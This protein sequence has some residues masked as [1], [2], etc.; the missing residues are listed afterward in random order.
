MTTAI[1]NIYSTCLCLLVVSIPITVTASGT[2]LYQSVEQALNTNPQLQALSHN[3]Q[4]VQ[5]DLNQ[6]RGGYLPTVD[7][8]LGYGPEQHSDTATRSLSSDN[9]WDPRTDATLRLTQKVYDGGETGNLVS[10]RKAQLD[11]AD[12]QLQAAAQTVALDAIRAHLNV[13]QQR[14]LV[15]LA[16]KN[17]KFHR[18]IL[19]SLAEKERAGAGSIADVTQTQ[20]RLAR[21]ESTLYLNQ[22]GL[23]QTIANYTRVVG[24][25]PG[26]LVYAG[27][28]DTEP[29]SLEEIQQQVEQNNPELLAVEAEFVEAES[30]LA[31]SHAN[32]KPKIDLELSSSYY[33]QLEGDQSWQNTNAAMLNLRW[34]LFSGGQDKAGVNAAMSRKNQSRSRR[35]VKLAELT[36]ATATAWTNYFSLQR[37]KNAYLD[38]VK[39]SRKTFDS[40]WK[41]FS[42][43]RRS[44]LDMLSA[45]NDYFESASQLMSLDINET[46]AAYQL[47]SLSGKIE[48]PRCPDDLP[49]FYRELN[50]RLPAPGSTVSEASPEPVRKLETE[51]TQPVQEDLAIQKSPVSNTAPAPKVNKATNSIITPA[52]LAPIEIGPCIN[53]KELDQAVAVI[54]KH[55]LSSQLTA[56]SGRVKVVRLLEGVYPP[57][58]ARQRL[59]ILKKTVDS[60]FV[61]PQEGQLGL[62][63]GSFHESKWAMQLAEL[64]EQQNIHVNQVVT[65]VEMQGQFVTVQQTNSE[66]TDLIRAQMEDLGLKTRLAGK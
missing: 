15:S 59:A 48:P 47:L 30:R 64:L 7:L 28:P 21:A 58:E 35:T 60:A 65:E 40:Y 2:T 26:A 14:E 12:Y 18:N 57:A 46:L 3:R 38:A 41:Q 20:A 33:D 17:L 43:S 32:Y 16:E 42:V 52:L 63:A 45:E 4:A 50:H 22:A 5:Y 29:Q 19:Q 13:F 37:Q 34:N 24:T 44:L 49:D 1:R 56:G 51:Q 66:I 27:K 23:Q 36:E 39:Y 55:G 9:D 8:L 54:R 6:A 11:S 62:Y 31:L 25:P 10:I 53:Q 61:L